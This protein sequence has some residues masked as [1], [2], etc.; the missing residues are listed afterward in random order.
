MSLGSARTISTESLGNI[1]FNDFLNGF[2]PQVMSSEGSS[3][4]GSLPDVGETLSTPQAMGWEPIPPQATVFEPR[5]AVP[6]GRR[7]V[8]SAGRGA[9]RV[10]GHTSRKSDHLSRSGRSVADAPLEM[11]G[12]H[13]DGSLQE[14]H[15]ILVEQWQQQVREAQIKWWHSQQHVK[16][17]GPFL[18][19]QQVPQQE[20]PTPP[21]TTTSPRQHSSQSG[22]GVVF[23]DQSEGAAEAHEHRASGALQQVGRQQQG[24][25]T[26]TDRGQGAARLQPDPQL[27]PQ[28]PQP[29]QPSQAW[30]QDL[31]YR[32]AGQQAQQLQ[33][34][35]Q[36]L[37]PQQQRAAASAQQAHLQR[38]PPRPHPV[39]NWDGIQGERPFNMPSYSPS[40]CQRMRQ[41]AQWQH[42]QQQ[43]MMREQH[44]HAPHRGARQGSGAADGAWPAQRLPHDIRTS[45]I[46]G[47]DLLNSG[48]MDMFGEHMPQQ[49]GE[50]ASPV[51]GLHMSAV[52]R[53]SSSESPGRGGGGRGGRRGKR[54]AD[55][56]AS[57]TSVSVPSAHSTAAAA[58]ISA[59][60]PDDDDDV[61]GS[62]EKKARFVWEE[63]VHR[64]F[65]EAVHSLGVQAAKPQ[66]IAHLMQMQGPGS[67]TRQNI[68]SHLQKYR[69]F[70]AK[71]AQGEGQ[72][73]G[74][75]AA[76]AA[77]SGRSTNS[78][79]GS[80]L[81]DEDPI[82]ASF[83]LSLDGS[84]ELATTDIVDPGIESIASALFGSNKSVAAEPAP[85]SQRGVSGHEVLQGMEED[86]RAS[87][88]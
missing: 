12:E 22:E 17:H 70:L 43:L 75:G 14:G 21:T 58:P 83:G 28:P 48:L 38:P 67:P 82:I 7:V 2:S 29:E 73:E 76:S 87:Q 16:Q 74:Q 19:E 35:A 86:G 52:G 13:R 26:D 30:E 31:Q 23:A 11:S 85:S 46:F 6:R 57:P 39:V 5:V 63:D 88:R 44:A 40:E 24:G 61:P 20:S 9:S 60:G 1:D 34:Q 80:K 3:Y 79:V 47:E 41:L 65:C 50:P 68:K 66:A 59:T 56:A 15:R 69:I 10:D 54:R 78:H 27:R 49:P 51:G 55:D 36:Q 33:Q 32:Q 25:S 42:E 8:K 18:H 71:R 45:E 64:R 53:Q 62:A 4:G 72:G 84:S 37:Q 77:S 81:G